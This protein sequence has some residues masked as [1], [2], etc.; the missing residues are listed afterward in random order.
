MVFSIEN[1]SITNQMETKD[2]KIGVVG[3]GYVGLGLTVQFSKVTTV[4]GY[5]NNKQRILDLKKGRDINFLFKKKEL[6]KNSINYT[7]SF[8]EL[9]NCNFYIICVPTPITKKKI[10]DL[11]FLKRSSKQIGKL[12]KKNDIV[13]YESTVYPGCT[14]KFVFQ[15]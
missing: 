4:N 15:F 7:N 2:L 1:N 6:L 8:K 10:P 11:R 12:L 9:R 13:V 3:L 14:K 5:D